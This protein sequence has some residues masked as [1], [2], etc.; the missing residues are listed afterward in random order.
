MLKGIVIGIFVYSL[1]LTVL[2]LYQN[3]SSYFEVEWLDVIMAGPCMWI[4]MPLFMISAFFY[5]KYFKKKHKE[6]AYKKKDARYIEKIVRKIVKKYKK[7][8]YHS[9]YI[10]FRIRQDYD[11]DGIEGYDCLLQKK[12]RN[13]HLNNRF[14]SLMLYQEEDTIKELEK[15]FNRVTEEDMIKAGDD[16]YFISSHKNHIFYKLTEIAGS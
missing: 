12:A 11:G 9:D 6:K 8:P 4:L 2:T 14:Q 15:Y 3:S 10:D 16:K 13:E 1:I 5:Q 7:S